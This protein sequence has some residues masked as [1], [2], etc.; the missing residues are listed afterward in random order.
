LTKEYFLDKYILKYHIYTKSDKTQNV[1]EC[2]VFNTILQ[3]N[4]W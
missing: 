3:S 1:L 2:S 4:S